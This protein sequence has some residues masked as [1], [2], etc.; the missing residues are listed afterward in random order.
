M[1]WEFGKKEK[2]DDDDVKNRGRAAVVDELEENIENQ[3]EY[4]V[5]WEHG[6]VGQAGGAY[7]SAGP[8]FDEA[9]AREPGDKARNKSTAYVRK[10]NIKNQ[11]VNGNTRA[12]KYGQ[13]KADLGHRSLPIRMVVPMPLQTATYMQ[14]APYNQGIGKTQ[15][16]LNCAF[17]GYNRSEKAVQDSKEYGQFV[18]ASI[19]ALTKARPARTWSMK[20]KLSSKLLV[21]S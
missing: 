10:A 21:C 9:R 3:G 2:E 16:E 15:D 12:E 18:G 4:A 7:D 13:P 20:G 5:P 6:E 14:D 17:V 8:A 19:V 1:P 11:D